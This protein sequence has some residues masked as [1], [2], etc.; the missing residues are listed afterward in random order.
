M[1]SR[2]A[3]F[4]RNSLTMSVFLGRKIVLENSFCNKFVSED[5]EGLP[6]SRSDV[7]QLFTRLQAVLSSAHLSSEG[8][9]ASPQRVSS[10]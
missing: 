8:P 3:T 5:E 4:T 1:S 9:F 6:P 2:L 10:F 7:L